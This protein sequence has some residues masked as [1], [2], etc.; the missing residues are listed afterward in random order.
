MNDRDWIAGGYI[1]RWANRVN[2]QDEQLRSY[3]AREV[4]R[5]TEEII[6]RGKEKCGN[7]GAGF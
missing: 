7:E 5:W 6:P 3:H 1:D 4:K 2:E